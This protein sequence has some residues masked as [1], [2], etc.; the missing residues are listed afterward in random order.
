MCIGI[1]FADYLTALQT[2]RDLDSLLHMKQTS[3][4]RSCNGEGRCKITSVGLVITKVLSKMRTEGKNVPA[5]KKPGKS[6]PDGKTL[7]MSWGQGGLGAAR[8]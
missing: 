1:T 6:T 5:L 8:Q 3:L 7:Q 4:Q 2:V